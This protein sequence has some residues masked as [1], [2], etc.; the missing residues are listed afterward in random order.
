VN[1]SSQFFSAFSVAFVVFGTIAN[2]IIERAGHK[3]ES[4]QEKKNGSVDLSGPEPIAVDCI[5][6]PV[7]IFT[8]YQY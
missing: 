2:A 5:K 1:R 3:S 7:P 8:V 6:K 4:G